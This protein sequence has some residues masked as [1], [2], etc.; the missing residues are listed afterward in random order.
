M[1]DFGEVRAEEKPRTG[2]ALFWGLV[3]GSIF[4]FF[5]ALGFLFE[6]APDFYLA[7]EQARD[8]AV[9]VVSGILAA[10]IVSLVL[11]LLVLRR[12]ASRRVVPYLLIFAIVFTATN[13]AL[14]TLMTLGKRQLI[15]EEQAREAAE[16][17]AAIAEIATA[18][19]HTNAGG[20]FFMQVHSRSAGEAGVIGRDTKAYLQAITEDSAWQNAQID[21]FA[22]PVPLPKKHRANQ[23]DVARYRV[24]VEK[25]R[26]VDAQYWARRKD[27]LAAYR[28]AIANGALSPATKAAAIAAFDAAA[29][30]GE[31]ER[32]SLEALDKSMI[33]DFEAVVA[34]MSRLVAL[35]DEGA[36][37]VEI[38]DA[39]EDLR[40]KLAKANAALKERNQRLQGDAH[41]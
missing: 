13:G 11:W 36:N 7:A 6:F 41:V 24:L 39:A 29:N 28:A 37:A 9:V 2:L 5:L 34:S 18:I 31:A 4:A 27:R 35:E 30:Q 10:M 19:A 16:T 32:A 26:L 12:G 8:A 21:Q 15:V 1:R 38:Y 25:A 17:K 33:R 20:R 3:V 23:A 40:A 14:V 22:H